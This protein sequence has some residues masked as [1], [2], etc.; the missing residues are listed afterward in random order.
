MGILRG[1]LPVVGEA[2][3]ARGDPLVPV[4]AS[5]GIP[6]GA[7]LA[8]TLRGIHGNFASE[9]ESV[10]AALA[11]QGVDFTVGGS[12]GGRWCWGPGRL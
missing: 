6:A 1:Q 9:I 2:A 4:R 10:K 7:S 8:D 11:G 12:G 3:E 5:L